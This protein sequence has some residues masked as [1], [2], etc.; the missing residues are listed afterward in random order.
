MKIAYP[1]VISKGEKMLIASVPDCEIDTQ[2][3]NLVDAIEM[4]RDAI[5]I[6]CISMQDENRELPNPS[7]MTAI[8]CDDGEFVT[9]VDVDL[10]AYRKS[11]EA[12]TVRKN[13]T[14]P[15]WLNEQAEK[16]NVNFSNVLQR[17]LKEELQLAD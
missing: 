8:D 16:A 7:D 9:L 14:L 15:S 2:G 13:L 4:A 10:A 3:E 12:K 17:A 1:V 5:S 6:W 11:I